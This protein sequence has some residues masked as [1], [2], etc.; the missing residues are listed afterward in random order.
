MDDD[1]L[2]RR[3]TKAMQELWDEGCPVAGLRQ[4][5]KARIALRRWRSGAR[6]RGRP[7]IAD[8]VR[9][10]TKG[11][12]EAFEPAP[13]LV[14]RTKRDYECVAERLAGELL[15]AESHQLDTSV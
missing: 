9:D 3:L 4:E 10:L 13:R 7:T 14:G 2:V 5:E 8:R 6:R 12:I 1:E 11:L 15:R